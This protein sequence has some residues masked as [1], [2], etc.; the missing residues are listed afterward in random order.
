M[1]ASSRTTRPDAVVK[2]WERKPTEDILRPSRNVF[3]RLSR[4]KGEGM[5]THLEAR[6]NSATSKR[7]ED[8]PIVSPINDKINEMR[9]RLEKLVARNNEA[10]PS[11]S[12]SL[13]NAM[14]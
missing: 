2:S 13:F 9:A 6:H 14:I 4:S 11:T 5:C 8:L 3:D 1:T 7:R 10:L 12:T